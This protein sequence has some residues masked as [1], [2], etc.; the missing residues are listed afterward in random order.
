MGAS[1]LDSQW[2]Q[3]ADLVRRAVRDELRAAPLPPEPEYLDMEDA[4]RVLG[5]TTKA[6]RNFVDS[7]TGP[8]VVRPKGARR[9]IRFRREDLRAWMVEARRDADAGA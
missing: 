7:G 8:R 6:L 5:L 4:A 1:P 2:S 3:L 9:M